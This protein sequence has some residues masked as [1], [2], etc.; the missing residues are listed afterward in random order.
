M[1][2]LQLRQPGDLICCD[3]PAPAAPARGEARVR[4]RCSGVCG[5]DQHA[6]AGRQPFFTYPRIPGHE[7]GV[8]VLAVGEG[9]TDLRP[10]DR[11]AVEPYLSCGRC[12][13]CRKGKTNCCE[14]L[15]VL[16]VHVDGGWREEIVVPAAK[17]HGST[18]LSFE[19]LALVETLGIGAHA[20]ARGAPEAGESALVVGAGPIGLAVAQFAVEAGAKVT[21]LDVND[22]RR[23]FAA[24][25]LGVGTLDARGLTPDRLRAELGGELPTLVFDATG[26]PGSLRT[27]FDWP[28]P[29]GRLV[30][31]SLVQGEI[32]F[33]DPNF[34][35][36]ELTLCA[37][38]N[39]TAVEFRRIIAL[40]ESGRIDTK[41]WITHRARLPEVPAVF[42]QWTRPETGVVKAMIEL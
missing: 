41:P 31:A 25:W 5:T 14:T 13:A 17:L 12:I 10:G 38:R 23:A 18:R 37:T 16:G 27:A 2:T 28:A 7:L 36:R 6:Y 15:Q 29:G 9:V 32:A 40:I 42:A 19:Q 33:D 22:A 8:E 3:T 30:F 11:C 4:V 1:Q 35:R 24:S 26:N 39:S 20:V 21:I 34:H